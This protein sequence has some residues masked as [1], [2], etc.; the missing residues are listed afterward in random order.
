MNAEYKE[1]TS[2]IAAEAARSEESTDLPC[3]FDW[4][5]GAWIWYGKT[6]LF[7]AAPYGISRDAEPFLI[8]N[9]A[10]NMWL[11]TLAGAD[12]YGMLLGSGLIGRESRFTGEMTILGEPV[13]LR[14]TWRILDER[15]VEIE[16]E[17]MAGNLWQR[18][19]RAR[20]TRVSEPDHRVATTAPKSRTESP[21]PPTMPD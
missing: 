21:L 15:T 8:Y 17:R 14:Q 13:R 11:L 10:A 6:G 5:S 18:W 16:T 3:D 2:R 1:F 20:L 19:D 12:A 4:L 9:A 7:A